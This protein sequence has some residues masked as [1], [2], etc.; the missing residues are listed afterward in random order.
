[1]HSIKKT[2]V[3]ISILM[4]LNQILRKEQH[5]DENKIV[6]VMWTYDTVDGCF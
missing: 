3:T 4:D 5:N 2:V 6:A 1:M